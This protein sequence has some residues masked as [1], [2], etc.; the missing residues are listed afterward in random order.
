M[1]GNYKKLIV[2]QKADQLA[3]TVYIETE[4]FPRR[5]VFGVTSQLRR[6]ALSVPTNIVEGYARRTR[7]ELVR[8][9][10]ISLGSFVE[11]EYLIDFS[12]SLGFLSEQSYQK[13]AALRAEV[14]SLLWKFI[15][16]I[17]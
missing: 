1:S 14:G 5:E 17:E 4:N 13:I 11:T 7:K 6:A 10:D 12:L 8:F 2:W 3:K 15:K 16:S 9:L